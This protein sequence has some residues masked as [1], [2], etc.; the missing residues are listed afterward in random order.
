[1]ATLVVDVFDNEFKAEEARLDLL[2]LQQ[3]HL[4]DLDD[5]LVV[6]RPKDDKI[7]LLHSSHLGGT[8]AFT[9]GV[10]GTL[11]GVMLLNPVFAVA[12]LASGAALG[13]AAGALMDA[14]IDEDFM[15]ELAEHLKPGKSALCILVRGDLDN[16]LRE[17]Q[18]FSG[19]VFQTTLREED[20]Q[21]LLKKLDAARAKAQS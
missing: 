21:R 10:L 14:G 13:G 5:S 2:R 12:G 3:E 17:L 11:L 20:E 4:A 9:G 7:K 16:V 1:M 15:K 18:K 8:G 19:R 6:V